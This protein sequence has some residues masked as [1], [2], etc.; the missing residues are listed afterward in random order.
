MVQEDLRVLIIQLGEKQVEFNGLNNSAP[1]VYTLLELVDKKPFAFLI[2][3]LSLDILLLEGFLLE[4]LHEIAGVR[5]LLLLFCILSYPLR[6]IF[7]VNKDII[8]YF[9]L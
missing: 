8:T 2:L 1:L 9:F 5:I 6:V 7:I 4:L 3:E